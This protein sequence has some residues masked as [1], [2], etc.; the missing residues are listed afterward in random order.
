MSREKET[1]IG[2]PE[3]LLLDRERSKADEGLLE[4]LKRGKSI[5][6]RSMLVRGYR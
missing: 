3:G 2:P 5:K 4:K 1:A 6:D